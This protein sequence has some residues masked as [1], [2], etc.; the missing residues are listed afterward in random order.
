MTSTSALGLADQV[1][2]LSLEALLV[3]GGDSRMQLELE[4][5]LN[6][7]G[8]A[9]R[10]RGA[11]AFGNCTA[12]SL[13]PAGLVGARA[14]HDQLKVA[15]RAGGD[16]AV[17]TEVES[18]F[19]EI[20]RGFRDV[21][22]LNGVDCDIAFCPSGTDAEL[23]VLAVAR[24]GGDGPIVNIVT[25]PSEVGSGTLNAAAGNHFN[26]HVP[27]GERRTPGEPIDAELVENVRVA[28]VRLRANDGRLLDQN[29]L[30]GQVDEMVR[31]ACAEGARV[32]LHVVTHSKTGVYAPSFD[33]AAQL[34]EEFGD[35]VTVVLDAAQGRLS[36]RSIRAALELEYLVLMTG[37]KFY[38]GPPFS[39]AVLVPASL[40]PEP[41]G[42]KAFSPG[43]C[44]YLTAPELPR[45]W[46]SLRDSVP[47]KPNVGLIIRWGTAL[48]QIEAYYETPSSLRQAVMR[49]FE[50]AVPA[51]LGESAQIEVVPVSPIRDRDSTRY[52]EAA[53]TVFPFFVYDADGEPMSKGTLKRVF[54]LLN[55]DLSGAL[56][57]AMPHEKAVLARQIHIGQP[58]TLSGLDDEDRSVLR[59]ALGGPMVTQVATD[60]RVGPTIEARTSWLKAQLE[61]LRRKIELIVAH[62]DVL[63]ELA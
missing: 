19:H 13:S 10:V 16:D 26:K 12:S 55:R 41:S 5:G 52:L 21:M 35:R 44:D 46:K 51:A 45:R 37:S 20:R 23:I 42:L 32:L 8:C 34:R 36:R 9:P 30:D 43:F 61:I 3:S 6:K 2:T 4:T 60:V 31:G 39:G 54:R 24:A 38:G 62:Y 56:P 11:V 15:A 57:S 17:V 59:V 40:R 29:E 48:A 7:Y 33:K 22:R 25:G 1:L 49:E 47:T 58:V 18:Q 28:T 50:S 63:E 27:C 14:I 53:T